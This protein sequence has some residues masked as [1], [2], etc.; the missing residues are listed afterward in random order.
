MK[1]TPLEFPPFPVNKTLRVFSLSLHLTTG[2]GIMDG[3]SLEIDTEGD[4]YYVRLKTDAGDLS[5]DSDELLAIAE[6]ADAMVRV[7]DAHSGEGDEDTPKED[8]A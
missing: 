8:L 4:G 7:M 6:W 1:T 2:P 3:A 5:L